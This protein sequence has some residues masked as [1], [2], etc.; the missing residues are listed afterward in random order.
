MLEEMA[1]SVLD[2]LVVVLIFLVYVVRNYFRH[3]SMRDRMDSG[4][5]G[6]L[7]L[8]Y[9]DTLVIL[10]GGT[11]LVIAVWLINGRTLADMGFVFGSSTSHLIGWIVVAV[12]SLL[13]TAQV[14][15]ISRNPKSAEAIRTAIAGEPGVVRILPKTE[16]EHSW[17]KIL[18]VTA[19]IT[20]EIIFR[21]YLI[22]FFALY[23]PLWWAAFVALVFFVA[24]HLYQESVRSLLKVASVGA[25]LSALYLL[26][27][28]LL[29]AIVLHAVV[30]L[31]N[32]AI[33][34]RAFQAA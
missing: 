10:W 8:E 9:K 15:L 22:W 3:R 1:V 23:L 19:G 6:I 33:V 2:Y 18:S 11:A 25:I 26:S 4:E 20:E 24:A 14:Y 7:M 21:G 29:A 17:F 34:R 13:L 28:S 31:T 30:D 16:Q 5:D 32:G 12:L 27:G